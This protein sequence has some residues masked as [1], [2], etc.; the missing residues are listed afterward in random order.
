M[1]RIVPGLV[2][3]AAALAVAGCGAPTAVAPLASPTPDAPASAPA[4]PGRGAESARPEP[5]AS[6]TPTPTASPTRT[7][8]ASPTTAPTTTPTTVPTPTVHPTDSPKAGK[9]TGPITDTPLEV[10]GIPVVS[11]DHRLSK[12]Y[13]PPWSKQ[14]NG[15]HPDATAAFTKLQAA[16][17]ADGLTLVIRSGYRSYA[18]QQGSFNHARKQY[19]EKTARLYFAEAGASEH[20]L[21][22]ALDAWDG[23]NRGTAFARTPHAK[24]LA[25]HAHEFGFIVRYPQDKTHI[26]GYAWESWH[27]RWVG[28][29]V[30]SAF[31]PNSSLTLEEYLG[32]A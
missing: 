25:A 21:G 7:P 8:S 3:L 6:A 9:A 30:S 4:Q 32:L 12:A 18:T 14:P 31:G 22:L 27:L 15:L 19:P 20:Q 16:A 11:K 28:T 23:K 13:V 2:G 10:R 17:K 26:T 1:Q 29:E 5:T 24:W